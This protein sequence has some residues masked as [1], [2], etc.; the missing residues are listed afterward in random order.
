VPKTTFVAMPY[1]RHSRLTRKLWGIGAI[2]CA[3]GVLM[4]IRGEIGNTVHE[5]VI[6]RSRQR[7]IGL[8]CGLLGL[9]AGLLAACGLQDGPGSFLADP[10]QYS[11]YHCNEIAAQ[12]KVLADREKELRNL[13]D[14]ADQ[15]GGGSVIGAVAYGPQYDTVRADEKILQR[16]AVEKNCGSAAGST[17]NSTSSSTS[18]ATPAYQSDQSIR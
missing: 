2:M 8:H 6:S 13:M 9:A 18:T 11:V 17:S 14:K 15:G 4:G 5:T 7:A 10:G 16:T 3:A 1:L 12:S